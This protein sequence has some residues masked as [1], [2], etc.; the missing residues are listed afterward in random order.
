MRPG[1]FSVSVN[2]RVTGEGYL[3]NL[4]NAVGMAWPIGFLVRAALESCDN[5]DSALGALAESKLIAPVYFSVAGVSDS[6][7]CIITRDR[8]KEVQRWNVHEMGF[9]VQPNM[10]HWSDDPYDDILMS[11][12]RRELTRERVNALVSS[13]AVEEGRP[14]GLESF[15]EILSEFPVNNSL[16]VSGTYMCEFLPRTAS[17]HSVIR[18]RPLSLSRSLCPSVPLSGSLPVPG[19]LSRTFSLSCTHSHSYS[20]TLHAFPPSF[21]SVVQTHAVFNPLRGF[22]RIPFLSFFASH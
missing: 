16:T 8:E 21:F 7:G 18:T 20:N 11:R 10:D 13:Q 19:T 2:F 1:A 3:K 14:L 5:Y 12:K 4:R 17:F 6:N 9:S 22:S 15:W